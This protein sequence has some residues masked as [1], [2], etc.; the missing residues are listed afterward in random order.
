[1]FFSLLNGKKKKTA[2]THD[3]FCNLQNLSPNILQFF[4]ELFLLSVGLPT[5]THSAWLSHIYYEIIHHARMAVY[6][7]YV[8]FQHISVFSEG[9]ILISDITFHKTRY[10][11]YPSLTPKHYI[12]YIYI[13][14]FF[15]VFLE[16]I[17]IL[18]AR[19]NF[20]LL[21]IIQNV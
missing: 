1:M 7:P 20:Q 17:A 14:R 19:R 12:E 21:K 3:V 4:L 10:L 18:C 9:N 2:R 11:V 15:R 8:A 5:V 6:Q 16:K 13:Y